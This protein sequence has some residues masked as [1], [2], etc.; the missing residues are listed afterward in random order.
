MRHVPSASA[1]AHEGGVNT[2]F[3]FSRGWLIRLSGS[4]LVDPSWLIRLR[5]HVKLLS[6]GLHNNSALCPFM[7]VEP[8]LFTAVRS[9]AHGPPANSTSWGDEFA[10]QPAHSAPRGISGHSTA[11]NDPG[12]PLIIRSVFITRNRP[13]FSSLSSSSSTDNHNTRCVSSTKPRKWTT[14]ST[15]RR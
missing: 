6:N 12:P 8:G 15:R 14:R 4:I 10:H 9:Y 11:E 3:L 7:E 1:L 5:D 13:P 2:M